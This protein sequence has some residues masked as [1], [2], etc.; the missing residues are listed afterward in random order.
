MFNSPG[1]SFKNNNISDNPILNIPGLT[2]YYDSRYI[3]GLEGSSPVDGAKIATWDC[4]KNNNTNQLAQATGAN[5]PIFWEDID[6]VSAV[7][8]TATNSTVMTCADNANLNSDYITHFCVFSFKSL[9]I[10]RAGIVAKRPS[11]VGFNPYSFD[12]ALDLSGPRSQITTASTNATSTFPNVG[13]NQIQM[14]QTRYDGA[15][16]RVYNNNTDQGGPLSTGPIVNS[17]GA[18]SVGEQSASLGRYFDGY[19]YLYAKYD[20]ALTTAE[21]NSVRAYLSTV[22]GLSLN[23]I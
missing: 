17:T 16:I 21:I 1:L 10:A 7:E 12:V 4:L 13:L 20:H 18:L 15:N 8:F 5:Q 22:Y 23:P 11:T 9:G 19:L 6:G 2:I 14:M 3:N